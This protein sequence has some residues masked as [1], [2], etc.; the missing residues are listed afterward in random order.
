M[1]TS[2][3]LLLMTEVAIALT[4]FSGIVATFQFTG[5]AHKSRGD[6][7]G[8]ASIVQLGLI[9][10]FMAF[11]PLAIGNFSLSEQSVWSICSLIAA[12]SYTV[13]LVNLFPHTRRM[14]FRGFNRLVIRFWWV[15]NSIGIL[16]IL[17]NGLR[18]GL[19]GE[20]APYV[21]VLLNPLC[22]IG[23]MFARLLLRPLWKY[24]R[25]QEAEALAR[26]EAT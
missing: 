26:S 19:N 25:Q 3:Q 7:I 2:D 13:Y 17:C 1:E 10:A 15:V 5:G 23:Y 11:L 12:I 4:G 6:V 14:R 21:A 20:A 18:I 22:F 8:L 16:V 24:I 9:T